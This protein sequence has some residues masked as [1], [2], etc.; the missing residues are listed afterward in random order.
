MK[1][2]AY[3]PFAL[4][5][6]PREIEKA[7][8]EAVKRAK[9]VCVVALGF[10]EKLSLLLGN[11]F[12]V[13][14]ELLILAE[15]SLIWTERNLAESMEERLTLDRRI[16]NFLTASRLYLDQTEHSVSGLFGNPSKELEQ[17]RAFKNKLYDEH[18]GYRFMEAL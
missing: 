17:V 15:A 5:D 18:G 11:F 1:Y 14:K 3:S 16:V 7:D 10:E 6:S 12:E 2:Q 8:Y 9:Y 4:E 13:E